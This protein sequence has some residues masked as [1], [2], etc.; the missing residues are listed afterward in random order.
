MDN[1]DKG[2]HIEFFSKAVE[3]PR[4]SKEEGRPI[5]EDKAYVRIKFP[6]DAKRVHVAPADEMHYV[7]HA[8]RQMTY[9]ERFPEHFAVF[10]GEADELVGGTPLSEM[11]AL[12][13]AK[14]KEFRAQSIKTVE[15]LA[16]LP[17]PA[18]SKLGFGT[19]DLVEAAKTYLEKAQGASEVNALK[20]ELQKLKA[21]MEQGE[22]APKADIADEFEGLSDEDLKNM[23]SDAGGSIPRGNAKRETLI[24]TL[25]ELAAEKEAA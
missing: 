19:R 2:L 10:E 18:I 8:Q 13:E 17:D 15:Q 1:P 25:R 20:A 21:I 3:H 22:P 24:K 23:I 7:S 6:G 16:G 12:S 9:A 4:K 11:P 14:R 5:Y